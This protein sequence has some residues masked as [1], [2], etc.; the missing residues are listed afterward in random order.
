MEACY[1]SLTPTLLL[2]GL[3]VVFMSYMMYYLAALSIDLVHNE[4]Y[5]YAYNIFNYNELFLIHHLQFVLPYCS[6]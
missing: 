2:S 5:I 4:S 1:I 3:N 6:I